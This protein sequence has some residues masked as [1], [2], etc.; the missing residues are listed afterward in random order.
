M[1]AHDEVGFMRHAQAEETSKDVK[2]VALVDDHTFMREGMKHFIDSLEGFACVW[3]AS[4]ASEALANIESHPPDVLVTDITLRGRGGLELIKDVHMLRPELPILVL[5]M[6][7]EEIYAHRAVKAGAKGYLMKTADY[8]SFANALRKVATGKLWLSEEISDTIIQAY[9][10]GT[11]PKDMDGLDSLTDREFEVFQL[12]GEGHG[13]LQIANAMQISP[14]TVDVHRANIRAK[15]KLGD[16]AAV[17]RHAIRWGESQR[18][19]A[20]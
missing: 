8:D 1:A 20:S 2:S 4:S 11:T 3:T 19:S 18:L 14:K 15:L 7:Q 16:G 9:T 10:S 12:M 6:H 13:T 5:S 17:M